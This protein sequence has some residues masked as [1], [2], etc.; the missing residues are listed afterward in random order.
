M[1][2]LLELLDLL[3]KIGPVDRFARVDSSV[4]LGLREIW[5]N[6]SLNTKTHFQ[7]TRNLRCLAPRGIGLSPSVL[8]NLLIMNPLFYSTNLLKRNRRSLIQLQIVN[9]L[10]PW[11]L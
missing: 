2:V 6:Q 4:N 8:P 3:L 7:L 1:A 5:L 9:A 11:E 10:G